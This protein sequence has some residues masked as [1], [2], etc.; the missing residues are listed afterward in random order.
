MTGL[1]NIRR[2]VGRHWWLLRHRNH[3]VDHARGNRPRLFV[4]VSTILHHDAQTGIQRVVRGIWSELLHR[5]SEGFDLLPIYATRSRGYRLASLE[6]M[7]HDLTGLTDTPVSARQGDIFLGLDLTAHLLPKY[8]RQVEEWRGA[9][10]T[11]HLMVY[12]LLPVLRPD[13][14]NVRNHKNFLLWLKLLAEEADQAICISQQVSRDLRAYL[15][16]IGSERTLDITNVR[17]GGDIAASRPSEGV[18]EEVGRVIRQARFRPAVLMV[19]T[20][21]PRK[22]YDAALRAFEHLWATQPNAPDLVIVGK[23]GWKTAELQQRLRAHPQHGR[24][25]HWLSQVTD[26]GLC[27]LY[28]GTRGLLIASRGE[29]MGLPLLEAVMHDKPVLARDLPVFREQGLPQV[30]YFEDDSPAV[31]G[32]EIMQLAKGKPFAASARAPSFTWSECVDHLLGALGVRANEAVCYTPTP[33][34]R[35]PV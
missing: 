34:Q 1:K 22:G 26:E 10:A 8:R 4:D 35:Q 6:A 18:C 9:G 24:K 21:E 28:E 17:L 16:D 31:L 20:I 11:V 25:L 30:R 33:S 3:F 27:E 5:D 13:W 19:G 29:G 32:A 15:H 12:D 7:N 23:P 2:L 14:F